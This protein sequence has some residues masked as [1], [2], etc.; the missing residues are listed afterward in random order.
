MQVLADTC[1]IVR[2]DAKTQRSEKT[3]KRTKNGRENADK[4]TRRHQ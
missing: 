2:E 1:L 3:L 4:I